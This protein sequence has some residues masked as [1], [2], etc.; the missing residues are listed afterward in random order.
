M[1]ALEDI[2]TMDH[3][4][5][6]AS[7]GDIAE[8]SPWVAEGAFALK[9]YADRPGMIDAFSKVM[10]EASRPDQLALIRAHPDL[11]GKAARSG[12]IAEASR[13]EQAGAGL[14]TLTDEEFTRFTALNN[15]YRERFEFPFIFAVRGATKQMILAAFET[16]LLNDADTE[17]QTALTQIARIFRFRLEDLVI[18]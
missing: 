9:P 7:F 3:A 17:F 16:R 2:N 4:A 1:Y 14:D 11:A 12:D 10:Q 8:H 18:E 6:L 15:A 5:F 13:S